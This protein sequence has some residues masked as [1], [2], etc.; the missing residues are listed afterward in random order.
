MVMY[1]GKVVEIG[2]GE[3]VFAEPAHPYTAALLASMP[4]MDPERRTTEAPLVGRS[5]EPDQPAIRL[6]LP[7]ALR[8][9]GGRVR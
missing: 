7:P 2:E 6:P 9:R 3:A 5:A 8:L 1:L 4:R